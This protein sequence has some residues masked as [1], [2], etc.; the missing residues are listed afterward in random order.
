MGMERISPERLN[1]VY[2]TILQ[3]MAVE[4]WDCALPSARLGF[5]RALFDTLDDVPEIMAFK[6]SVKK[7]Y[8][9][10]ISGWI[11]SACES[12]FDETPEFLWPYIILAYNRGEFCPKILRDRLF[13]LSLVSRT[14]I[15][16][17]QICQPPVVPA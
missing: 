12:E 17:E 7:D 8:S 10:G 4:A 15:K 2:A 1:L 11:N 3:A 9:D 5:L 6:E 13:A 14:S 16:K